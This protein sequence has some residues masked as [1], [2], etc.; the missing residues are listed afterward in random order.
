[1]QDRARRIGRLETILARGDRMD[2]TLRQLGRTE[3][4]DRSER[5]LKGFSR[6]ERFDRSER[7]LKEFDRSERMLRGFE[8][9]P[10]ALLARCPR[11]RNAGRARRAR[12]ARVHSSAPLGDDGPPGEPEPPP[13][14][15]R[16][17]PRGGAA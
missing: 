1:V 14:P 13:P 5:M 6:T 9:N 17:R 11:L 7:M 3:R 10:K 2:R 12:R 4:F 15:P 8:H 16:P